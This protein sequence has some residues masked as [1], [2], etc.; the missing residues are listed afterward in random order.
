MIFAK[1]ASNCDINVNHSLRMKKAV[2]EPDTPS[3]E[4]KTQVE[5]HS[6]FIL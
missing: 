4:A 6:H 2:F 3:S 5:K 1:N